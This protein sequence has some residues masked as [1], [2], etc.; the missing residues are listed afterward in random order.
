MKKKSVSIILL[1]IVS[2]SW[3]CSKDAENTNSNDFIFISKNKIWSN[4]L[5]GYDHI[6]SHEYYPVRSNYI[7]IGEDTLLN[8]QKWSKL[9]VSYDENHVD[10]EFQGGYIREDSKQVFYK[11]NNNDEEILYDF[12]LK[13]GDK[14]K[15]RFDSSFTV[16]SIK[17]LPILNNEYRKHYYLSTP[18][19]SLGY[20]VWI[21]GI[22][23]ISGF[24]ENTGN[25]LVDGGPSVLLCYEE[26]NVQI[27]KDT[28]YGFDTCFFQNT[29]KVNNYK[30]QNDFDIY[31]NPADENIKVNFK[32]IDSKGLLL[33][34]FSV[35][36]KLIYQKKLNGDKVFN[37]DIDEYFDDLV[38]INIKKEAINL[39]KKIMINK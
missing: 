11:W 25:I 27:Y 14:I 19:S 8:G 4:G 22:G 20:V 39:S 38:I 35:N 37:I 36:G 21:E 29:L 6:S 16:D 1:F 15:L 18:E 3:S 33:S 2:L 13:I 5:L 31:P 34:L 17:N 24:F 28:I 7:K 23:S 12:S 32:N 30:Y 9:F 10:W 26:N